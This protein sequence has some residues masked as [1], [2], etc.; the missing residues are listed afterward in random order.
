M[1]PWGARV[2]GVAGGPERCET[3]A[4]FGAHQTV[5]HREGDIAAA[6]ME[7]T[8][9]QGVN[10]VYDPVGG[11]AYT[12]ASRC[13][14]RDARLVII[15]FAS[16]EWAPV[17]VR[18][19]VQRNYSVVGAIPCPLQPGGAAGRPPPAQRSVG[20]GQPRLGGQCHLLV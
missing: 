7:L 6:V 14:A 10:V 3:A 15:G 2:I 20:R 5:D 18:H 13:A 16:G 4:G 17:N 1:P 19:M 11:D 9:G 8:D 12:A